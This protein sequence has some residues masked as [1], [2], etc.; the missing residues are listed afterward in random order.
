MLVRRSA[1]ALLGLVLALPAAAQPL[2]RKD[3]PAPLQ[4]W[5]PWALDGADERLCPTVG[6]STVCLWPGRLTLA[7][8]RTEARF[9]QEVV[10]D[11]P[12]WA[13]LPGSDTLWPQEVRANGQ[14]IAVVE[15]EGVPSVWLGTGTFKLD[16][17]LLYRKTPD[18]LA[19]PDD[20]AL[21]DLTVLGKGVPFPK[22]EEDGTLLL[23]QSA[24]EEEGAD[25]LQ[26]KVF[27]KLRDGIPL[28]VETRVALEVAGKAR[29]VR[30]TGALP[31][32]AAPVSVRGDLPARLDGAELRIQV[33]PGKFTIA[34][35]SRLPG[36]VTEIKPP[37]PLAPWPDQEIWVFA[38]NEKLRQVEIAG[39]SA[40]D[41]SRTDL[42]DDWKPLAAYLL[43]KGAG[44]TIKETRRG[45]PEPAP[46]QISLRRTLWL[47][48][49]GSAFTVQ[50]TFSGTLGR[51]SRLNLAKP[52]ELG[53]VAVDGQD[54]LVTADPASSL[55][56]VELR[57]NAL[58][59]GADGRLPRA[60][61]L[62]ATGWDANVQSLSIELHLPPGWRVFSTGGVDRSPSAWDAQWTLFSFFFVLLTA[63][64]TG[65]L[66]GRVW[67]VVALA[68]LVVC[69]REGG[70]PEF[71]WITLLVL[72]ALLRVVDA[73]R[74]ARVLKVTWAFSFVVL[75]L[76]AV[77]FF[78]KQVR[79]GLFP[80]TA[81][82]PALG[83]GVDYGAVSG[84]GFGTR[85]MMPMTRQAAPM[86]E[87]PKVVEEEPAPEKMQSFSKSSGYTT[88][89]FSGASN[90]LY[91]QEPNAIVQTGPGVPRWRWQSHT[92]SWSGPVD[93]GH[94]FRLTL[95]SPAA[96]LFLAL[97][98]VA[99]ITALA[100]RFASAS[101]LVL[102]GRGLASALSL[103]M[104][105]LVG[106][107]PATAAE[108]PQ[109]NTPNAP[110]QENAS[111]AGAPRG[112]S[113]LPDSALLNELKEK[114]LRP[115]PCAPDCVT[116]ADVLLTVEGTELKITAEVHAAA[117]TAWTIPG[118]A[119]SWVPRRVTVGAQ[120]SP[121]LVR[122]DDGFLH[123]R[124][125][126]GVHRVEVSGPL[127]PRDS[128]TLQFPIKPR[129]ARVNAPDWQVDGVREEGGIDGSVQLTRRLKAA[130]AA[131]ATEG[132]Y[133]PWVEVR[134]TF[135]IGVSW[136]AETI[137]HRVTP[138]G[139]PLVLK[140]PL[141]KGMLATGDQEV[142]DGAMVITL[143]PDQ[144]D[145]RWTSVIKPTP[146]EEVVLQ[147][148][149]GK[150]WSEVWVVRC[151]PI[152]QC[153]TKGLPPVSRQENGALAEEYRPWP[154]ETLS[155]SFRKPAGIEGETLT[156]DAATLD[157]KPGRR[158]TDATL[159]IDVR[160]SRST[161]LVLTL[162]A[163]AE[164]QSLT[165][166][167]EHRPIRPDGGKLTLTMDPGARQVV[168]T[169]R[170]NEGARLRIAS[171]RVSLG[172]AAVNVQ[173]TLHV[174]EGR[175]LLLAGGPSWG[176]SVLF[177]G[178]FLVMLLVAFLL[179]RVPSSPL[180]SWQWLLLTLGLTQIP[181]VA[182]ALVA[183][184]FLAFAWRERKAIEQPA[185]HD[186]VQIALAI[187]TLVF[188]GCLYGAVHEGLLL[189]P[190]MQVTGNGS[191][192]DTLSWYV[193]RTAGDTPAA[194]IVSLPIWA[195]RVAMLAWSLWLAASL[196]KWL[197]WGWRAYVSGGGW[198]PLRDA[199]PT[200]PPPPPTFV[201][202]P[203]PIQAPADETEPPP[204]P[205]PP[206]LPTA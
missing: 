88:N 142:K 110:N 163:G 64:A 54:Q 8:D 195:Y 190:D 184:W 158:L 4:T 126:A 189:M 61:S 97:L 137:V 164:V 127:P 198:K 117:A 173:T 160:A 178:V 52:G 170:Q 106:A 3:V 121:G 156:I 205:P 132:T 66:F 134:R 29:E 84:G 112:G 162:P 70:A 73:P 47:D 71:V 58:N 136:T 80:Q 90:R 87:A 199:S 114:L 89:V 187:W 2:P 148:A 141:L 183:G 79:Q 41:T 200:T 125:P 192:N 33:R 147:A 118:P 67:G 20:T 93:K 182:A 133:E 38:P 49:G 139:A 144:T 155:L 174:P 135:D 83:G 204:P 15:R 65:K 161:P 31:A 202:P 92:L 76:L 145:A 74:W 91:E 1:L 51:T 152:W 62:P 72:T 55:P 154:G 120:A 201:P 12:L 95:L 32:G 77:P 130:G 177:W 43:E 165:V 116:T 99:L 81:G 129:R 100:V 9:S 60:A 63:I 159:T 111:A 108:P 26:L 102:P 113:G 115:A 94:R 188:L 6:D 22:R 185:L 46:D 122:L 78:I 105:L 138:T 56:G 109:Q 42:S 180:R 149:E 124:L 119:T 21:I 5:V 24:G 17:K 11:R 45:E 176:P 197:A 123:L 68:T 104:A 23:A 28:F 157:V 36:N 48:P 196:V 166:A 98:R 37:A 128:V 69:H 44:L 27:R 86:P 13:S 59:V 131:G 50:D 18:S 167:G 103:L 25:E 151:G 16:G 206:P 19:V 179:G 57:K 101:P 168:V 186:L 181:I 146:G 140:V 35:E 172:R 169:W 14:P 82:G 153:V 34:I 150:P 193:D 203:P 10:T 30:L 40:I 39:A 143:G 175:W 171:P 107:P 194:W 7:V 75:A 53:R 191:T 85:G 96:N